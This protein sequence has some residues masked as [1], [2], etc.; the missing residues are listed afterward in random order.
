[1]FADGEGEVPYIL[2]SPQFD[3]L[4]VKLFILWEVNRSGQV[5]CAD[6]FDIL[7]RTRTFNQQVLTSWLRTCP[8]LTFAPSFADLSTAL[9]TYLPP[10]QDCVAIFYFF[11]TRLRFLNFSFGHKL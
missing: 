11:F 2:L 1:M 9:Y 10:T 6:S 8:A 4:T 3:S 7:R 5:I